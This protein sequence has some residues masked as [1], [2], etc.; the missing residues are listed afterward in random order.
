VNPDQPDVISFGHPR[1]GDRVAWAAV[2]LLSAAL[3]I[4][5]IVALHYH[6]QVVALHRQARSTPGPAVSPAS[7]PTLAPSSWL[8]VSSTSVALLP[9]GSLTGEVTFIAANPRSGLQANLVIIAHVSGGRPH[10]TYALTGGSCS[11]TSRHRWGVQWAA[12]VTDTHGNAELV[13]SV[14]PVSLTAHYWLELT[15]AIK[16]L[17]PALAGDFAAATDISA[18][19]SGPPMCGS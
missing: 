4:A 5:I 8:T 7:P 16:N 14:Q 17:Q 11:S 2:A 6:G 9:A 10:T 13:G 19:R 18:Y 15:P 3:V 12:G 1:T